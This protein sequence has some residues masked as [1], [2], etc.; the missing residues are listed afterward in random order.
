[1]RLEGLLRKP[2]GQR[3]RNMAWCGSS[4]CYTHRF[5][6]VLTT[7]VLQIRA[8]MLSGDDQAPINK[9]AVDGTYPFM[10]M[11]ETTYKVSISREQGKLACFLQTGT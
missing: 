7:G 9:T 1:M 3:R 6:Q 4:F 11:H 10:H 8:C 5:P 2:W